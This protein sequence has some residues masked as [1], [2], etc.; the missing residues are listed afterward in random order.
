MGF[1]ETLESR[2]YSVDIKNYSDKRV[3]VVKLNGKWQCT[4]KETLDGRFAE[5]TCNP[6]FFRIK[7]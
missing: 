4:I 3:T 2:G 7:P 5:A 1:K 6:E